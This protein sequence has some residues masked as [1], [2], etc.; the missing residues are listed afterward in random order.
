MKAG[1]L[2]IAAA[3]TGVL[4]AVLWWLSRDVVTVLP[5]VGD[6][7]VEG[8]IARIQTDTRL[9]LAATF[10]AGATMVLATLAALAT[11]HRADC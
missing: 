7:P 11:R 5:P 4:A 10:L 6:P 3:V 8:V 2:T 1:R 9:L